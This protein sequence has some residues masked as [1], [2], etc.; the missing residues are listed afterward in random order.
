MNPQSWIGLEQEGRI[1]RE[2]WRHAGVVVCALSIIPSNR[3]AATSFVWQCRGTRSGGKPREHR[4]QWVT[5]SHHSHTNAHPI[6]LKDIESSR[7]TS[8]CCGLSSS[9][10]WLFPRL[11]YVST[12]TG[13]LL[14]LVRQ[15][16]FC[17]YISREQQKETDVSV[18]SWQIWLSHNL[19]YTK[20]D[21]HKK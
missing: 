11:T 17:V 12:R 21:F 15:H 4:L 2:A 14:I 8:S 19:W 6:N 3:K 13:R 5:I 10:R 18:Q 1:S 9:G 7:L 20:R 16:W